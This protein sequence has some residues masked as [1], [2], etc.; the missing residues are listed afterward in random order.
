MQFISKCGIQFPSDSRPILFNY[1][2]YSKDYIVDQVENS[3]Q[4]LQIHFLDLLLLH[5]P[6]PL[7][8]SDEI[9]AA[10]DQLITQRKIKAIGVSNFTPSHIDLIQENHPVVYNQIECSLSQLPTPL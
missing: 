3:L 1:Y 6:S 7:I 5:R 9:N 8:Q 4:N 10:I 2:T